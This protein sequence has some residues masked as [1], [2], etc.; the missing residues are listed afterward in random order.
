MQTQFAFPLPLFEPRSH[1]ACTQRR[2]AL[3]Q[4]GQGG[5][6]CGERCCIVFIYIVTFKF[7]SCDYTHDY[8]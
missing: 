2:R 6:G 5:K 7:E 1:A 4:G 3:R 8:T